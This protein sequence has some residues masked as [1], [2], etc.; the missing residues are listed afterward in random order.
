MDKRITPNLPPEHEEEKERAM[1][2]ATAAATSLIEQHRALGAHLVDYAG[3]TMPVRYGSALDEHRAVRDN[4]GMFDVSHMGELLVEGSEA[5]AALDY[6]L[7]SE[8]SS[9]AAG[10][11]EYSMI[12]APDGGVIDDLIV[13]RLE[14]DRFLIVANASN[15]RHVSAELGA[16]ITGQRFDARLRDDTYAT[17][18]IALQ[19]P[20]AERILAGVV[21]GSDIRS[22]RRYSIQHGLVCGVDATVARTGYTGE[23]GFEIFASWEDAAEIWNGLLFWSDLGG[24][25]PCGLAARDTLRLEA[26]MPLYGNELSRETTPFD[27]GLGHVVKFTKPGDFVGRRALEQAAELGPHTRL[28]GLVLRGRGIA[29]HGYPVFFPG[30]GLPCGTVTSGAPSPTLGEAIAMAYVTDLSTKPGDHLEIGIRR[31]R[32]E[33]EVVTLPFYR[34][35]GNGNGRSR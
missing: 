13:Y 9:L 25:V 29:R 7:V 5:A 14:A 12:C 2:Q 17:S 19:G 26:G 10:R 22:L 8:P 32:V 1:L 15:A 18:L 35:E 33:A 20:Q 30:A 3:W 27:A 23:D 16:R 34:R 21:S 24:P 28:I 4:A 31:E 6:G 11:A